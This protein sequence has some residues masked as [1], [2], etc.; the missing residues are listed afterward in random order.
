MIES[1]KHTSLLSCGKENDRK[2]FIEEAK[3][4]KV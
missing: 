3:G 2:S 4:V 1:N